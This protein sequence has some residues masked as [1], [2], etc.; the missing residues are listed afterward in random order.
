[1]SLPQ[2]YVNADL[3]KMREAEC[4]DFRLVVS[5]LPANKQIPV[6]TMRTAIY[7]G[8]SPIE[9]SHDKPLRVHSLYNRG[10]ITSDHPQEVFSQVL[11]TLHFRG[12]VLTAGLGIGMVAVRLAR[13]PAV[14]SVTV[15]EKEKDVIDLV[16]PQLP[17]T[18]T[19][20]DIVHDDIFS[21]LGRSESRFDCMY[22]DIWTGTGESTWDAEVVPLIRLAR[23]FG[24][25]DEVYIKCWMEDVMKG[26][27]CESMMRVVHQ[28]NMVKHNQYNH[29]RPHWAFYQAA[30]GAK[31]EKARERLLK[32]F[33]HRVGSDKW[34][35]TFP[36]DH[37]KK[38]VYTNKPSS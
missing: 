38:P 2:W 11:D 37:F 30:M 5:K 26:Q 6:V 21:Y 3:P 32:L 9:F 34:E 15:V 18:E 33:V 29:F 23:H 17:K 35:K 31:D 10:V 14:N 12:D 16:S 25:N 22:L 36:W 19:P 4:G 7:S 24:R 28:F 27:I 1:M 8:V 20:I 13:L